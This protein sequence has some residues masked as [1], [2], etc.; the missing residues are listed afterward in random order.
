MR[1]YC[2]ECGA[3]TECADLRAQRDV[4]KSE[5]DTMQAA[6]VEIRAVLEQP[7]EATIPDLI[8]S[9]GVLMHTVK[10]NT[11][12]V[13]TLVDERNEAREALAFERDESAK[14]KAMASEAKADTARL[15]ERVID[16]EA[17][18]GACPACGEDVTLP[19]YGAT[20]RQLTAE[21]DGLLTALRSLVPDDAFDKPTR[22]ADMDVVGMRVVAKELRDARAA[23]DLVQKR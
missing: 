22:L 10:M 20:G 4:L 14:W 19:D 17:K 12:A 18:H 2:K 15:R 8:Y 13:N 23:I 6:L 1:A 9:A 16:A 5:R 11:E 21:R 7:D 3:I